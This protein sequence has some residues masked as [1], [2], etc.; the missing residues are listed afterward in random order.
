MKIKYIMTVAMC[1][2]MV[3]NVSAAK[4]KKQSL[5]ESHPAL[6]AYFSDPAPGAMAPDAKGFIRRWTLLEPIEKP[7]RSNTVFVDSYVRETF[8]TE[9]FPGQLSCLPKE[10]DMV[11]VN[12]KSLCWHALDSKLYNVK[13][14]RYATGLERERYGLIFWAVTEIDCPEPLEN[15]RL[16]AGSNSASLWWVDGEEV[17]LLSNDRRMVADDG[18]SRRLSLAAGRHT[19][20]VAVINGPGMS[21]F[22]VR[23]VGEDGLP[24]TNYTVLNR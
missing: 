9:M 21:D 8:Y 15:V 17:L 14:F 18:A 19:I 4:K 22:C 2:L 7:N 23:F 6:A 16:M 24:V 13:L 1:C 12:G 10:G 11:K 5:V 20:R 3:I